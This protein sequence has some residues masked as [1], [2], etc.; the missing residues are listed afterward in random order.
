MVSDSEPGAL[1]HQLQVVFHGVDLLVCTHRLE[2]LPVLPPWSA[3]AAEGLLWLAAVVERLIW[4]A[5]VEAA[6]S[7]LST[8]AREE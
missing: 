6:L 1:L 8:L 4:R 5:A 2:M 7:W 3:A